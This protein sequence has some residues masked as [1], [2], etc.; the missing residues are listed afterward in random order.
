[1]ISGSPVRKVQNFFNTFQD[2]AT[3]FYCATSLD[4]TQGY[5]SWNFPTTYC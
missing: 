1:M 4:G 2:Y 5:E 3:F